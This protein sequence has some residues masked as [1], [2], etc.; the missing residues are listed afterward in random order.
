MIAGVAGAVVSLTRALAVDLAPLRVNCVSPGPVKTELW[1]GVPKDQLDKMLEGFKKSSLTD[2][3]AMPE[4]TAESYL[5]CMRDGS[6]TG[7][8]IVT[9]GGML[10]K[11]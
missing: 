6:L 3:V 8:T 4:D 10:L 5:G 2:K 7:Q 1:D 11:S 9:E